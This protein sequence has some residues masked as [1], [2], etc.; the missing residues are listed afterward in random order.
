MSKSTKTSSTP[1]KGPRYHAY[2]T[3]EYKIGGESRSDWM[4]IGSGFSH[5]DGKGFRIVL[6]AIPTDGVVVL[7]EV[8][9][10]EAG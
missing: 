3:R 4:R 10:N 5:A 6:S 2:V 9:E 7:R 8:E 1:T